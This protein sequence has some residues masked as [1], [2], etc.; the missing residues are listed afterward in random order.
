MYV[1]LF[2][3]NIVQQCRRK[4]FD[5]GVAKSYSDTARANHGLARGE[6]ILNLTPLDYPKTHLKS[7]N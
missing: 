2:W 1:I 7:G 4:H 6:K 3:G 5:I